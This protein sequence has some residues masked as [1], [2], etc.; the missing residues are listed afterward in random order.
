MRIALAICIVLACVCGARAA[1]ADTQAC[2]SKL[3]ETI[4][5]ELGVRAQAINWQHDLIAAQAAQRAAEARVKALES[6]Y[7]PKKD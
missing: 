7:E 1:D 2:Q 4:N 3:L 6:K 5:V